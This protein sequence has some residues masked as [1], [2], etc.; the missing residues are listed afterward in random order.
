MDSEYKDIFEKLYQPLPDPRYPNIQYWR[1]AYAP[2]DPLTDDSVAV[3]QAIDE[4]E[5][6]LVRSS[7]RRIRADGKY[8]LLLNFMEMVFLP[9]QV[10]GIRFRGE[11]RSSL[12]RAD[13]S[14]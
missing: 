3:R 2:Q 6:E 10:R 11:E 9:M 8:F 1:F 5:R 13:V 4:A 14:R 7:R 12:L